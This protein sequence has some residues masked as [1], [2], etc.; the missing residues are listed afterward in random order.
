MIKEIDLMYLRKSRADSPNETVEEVLERHERELQEL[1]IRTLGHTIEE[2]YIFREVVSGE[3]IEDRPEVQKILSR[4]ERPNVKSV[5]CI[6]PQRL[7]R[8]DWE[9][10]GKILSAFKYSHTLVHTVD[11]SYDL[12]NKF[13]YK[14]FKREL[15]RGNDYLEYF[16]EIQARGTLRS[17]M[18]GNYISTHAPYGYDK[19]KLDKKSHSL[20]P[21]DNAKNVQLIFDL[22]VNKN[23]GWTAIGNQ[24]ESLGIK[25]PRTD[26]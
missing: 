14:T 4:I 7:S 6:E 15:E 23:M 1:A 10:G 12:N 2:Q 17:V 16:K 26:H 18:D 24:L 11:K 22:Y 20:V 25:P 3:T 13:D 5:F 19:I 21:N 9:D 8:G